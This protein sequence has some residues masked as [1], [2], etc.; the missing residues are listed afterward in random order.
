MSQQISAHF[1][2][3]E[4]TFSQTAARKGIDNTPPP[5]A[6][7]ELQRLCSVILEPLRSMVNCAIHIDSGY[8]SPQLNAAVG[9]AQDSAHMSGRAADIVLIG[10]DLRTAFGIV[11]DSALPFDQVIIECNA[12]I[13]VSIAPSGTAPRKEALLASGY[14]GNW[15]YEAAA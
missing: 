13:H 1:S 14:P 11:R 3:D 7:E 8:R 5:E 4:L 9:G 15:H 2:L 12:W 6:I 10:L